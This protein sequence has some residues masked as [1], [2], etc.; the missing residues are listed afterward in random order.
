MCNYTLVLTDNE[1][2]DEVIFDISS[3]KDIAFL[4][5]LLVQACKNEPDVTVENVCY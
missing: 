3:E 4:K 2:D 1:T 5:D